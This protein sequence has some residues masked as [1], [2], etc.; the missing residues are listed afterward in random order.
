MDDKSFDWI[1]EIEFEDLLDGDAKLVREY[2]G[3]EVLISL[4]TN[5]PSI[6]IYIST[7]PLIHMKKRYV[8]KHF[9]GHNIKELC[10]KLGASERF[11]YEVVE[12][13]AKRSA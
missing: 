11:V 2:C 5:L 12:G 9:N 10:V 8:Q 1:R 4:W 6:P 3:T 7:K 13:L